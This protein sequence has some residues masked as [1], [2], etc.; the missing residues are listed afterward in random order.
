MIEPLLPARSPAECVEWLPRDELALRALL[1][2]E[3]ARLDCFPEAEGF[4]DEGIPYS[5][6]ETFVSDL[7]DNLA[8]LVGDYARAAGVPVPSTHDQDRLDR[9]VADYQRRRRGMLS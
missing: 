6:R 5:S 4:M 9:L 8:L 7:L 1:A 2:Y 3:M